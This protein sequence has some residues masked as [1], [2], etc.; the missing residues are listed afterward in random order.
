MSKKCPNCQIEFKKSELVKLKEG[1]GAYQD[2]SKY[3]KCHH[4]GRFYVPNIIFAMVF[5]VIMVLCGL[6]SCILAFFFNAPPQGAIFGGVGFLMYMF[7]GQIHQ[8]L[9]IT[10][11]ANTNL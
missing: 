8:Y 2:Q 4:C 5:L 10:D 11:V 1:M 7:R 9:P 3:V 6:I